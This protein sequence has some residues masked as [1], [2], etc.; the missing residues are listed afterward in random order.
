MT[1]RVVMIND[2]PH[3]QNADGG[4]TPETRIKPVDL[5]R[6]DLVQ[7]LANQAKA[8]SSDISL[9]KGNALSEIMAFIDVSASEYGVEIGGKKGNVTLYSFDKRYKV[10]R[11]ISERLVFDERLQVAQALI[12]ECITEWSEGINDNIKALI[13]DAFQ[14]DKEGKVSTA[15]VLGLR[16]LNISYD[17]WVKAMECIADSMSTSGSKTYVRIYERIGES[18]EYKPI[19]LDAAAA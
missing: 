7:G 15:R 9:F 10:Q 16:R 1:N 4:Y 8:L 14:V 12:Y 18:D 5:T 3:R 6:D 11:A 19:P 17:K 2:E 13:D